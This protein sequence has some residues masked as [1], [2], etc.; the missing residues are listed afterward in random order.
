MLTTGM[1]AVVSRGRIV[2]RYS[3][4]RHARMRAMFYPGAQVLW[5]SRFL[6]PE[7][8]AK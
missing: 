1:Y 4:N 6:P 8:S 7:R 5:V 2:A 3:S